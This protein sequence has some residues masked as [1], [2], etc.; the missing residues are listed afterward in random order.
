M[1]R[2]FLSAF[3]GSFVLA[4]LRKTGRTGL[5]SFR[6]VV[7]IAASGYGAQL[8]FLLLTAAA[9]GVLGTLFNVLQGFVA[10]TRPNKRS[11]SKR[12]LEVSCSFCDAPP[13]AARQAASGQGPFPAPFR[14]PPQVLAVCL[15]SLGAMFGLALGARSCRQP[16]QVW[17]DA[18]FGLQLGCGDGQVNDLGTLF[19]SMPANT[20]AMLLSNGDASEDA[21]CRLASDC[22]FT[23]CARTRPPTPRRPPP[24]STGAQWVAAGG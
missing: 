2:C 16:P 20:I 18:G 6:G 11:H 5:L 1:W 12:L 14:P 23:L 8:P 3:S 13:C 9:T 7:P 17:A 21:Q 15:V 19:F 4:L 10:A 24:R 22:G